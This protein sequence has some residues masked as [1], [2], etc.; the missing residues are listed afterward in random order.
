VDEDAIAGSRVGEPVRLIQP[1][2]NG[3]LVALEDFGYIG[4]IGEVDR[5]E[6]LSH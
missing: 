5:E 6:L 2:P 3:A 1:A 4:E